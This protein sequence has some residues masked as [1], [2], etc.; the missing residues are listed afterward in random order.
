VNTCQFEP[1][2]DGI[3]ILIPQPG[4]GD[5]FNR[6]VEVYTT[7]GVRFARPFG[8][9]GGGTQCSEFRGCTWAGPLVFSS[10]PTVKMDSAS[11]RHCSTCSH[12]HGD[13][14]GFGRVSHPSSSCYE[15]EDHGF[16]GWES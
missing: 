5:L 10:A 16:S 12:R 6:A 1:P 13:S 9:G 15:C 7:D 8:S 3:Y 4:N 11:D 14:D 2:V